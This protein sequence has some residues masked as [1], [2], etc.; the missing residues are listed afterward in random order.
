MAE[1]K[2]RQANFELLRIIAM[3]MVIVL[4]YIIKGNMAV[5]LSADGSVMNH[6]W[7]LI[8]GF[9]NVAV[10]VYVLISG[11]FLV[12]AKWRVSKL[13]KLVC[14]VL[15]YSILAGLL[16]YALGDMLELPYI[17]SAYSAAATDGGY[18]LT[19]WLNVL[20]PIEYE[21]YWFATAYVVMYM[22]SPVLAIAVKQMEQKQ[23]GTVIIALL[24][25]FCLPKSINPYLIPTDSYGYDFG[26]FIC[27]FLIAGY[28][29][30]YGIKL[31]DTKKKCVLLYVASVCVNFGICA[32][33]GAICRKTG[34]LEY[35]MDMTYAYNY[36]LVLISSVALFYAFTYIRIPEGK[37]ADAV[38]RIAPL[39]FGVYLL[40]ENVGIRLIWPYLLGSNK[41]TNPAAEI[42]HMI[43]SVAV[44]FTAGCLVDCVRKMLFDRI[45]AVLVRRK[46]VKSAD[47]I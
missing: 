11:Y 45:E 5:K 10:N 18:N 1:A 9:C 19:T 28:I 20:L 7:W 4:H 12:E 16:M 31:L 3:M 37:T 24:C 2:K 34:K 35:Y 33:C 36:F 22:L 26:W 21:H 8:D 38:C 44:V 15:F 13:V 25:F 23:L 42:L 17:S 29:R 41:M 6:I 39:T 46:Q 47:E 40:H 43:F 32:L 14:Q 30:L 27:L